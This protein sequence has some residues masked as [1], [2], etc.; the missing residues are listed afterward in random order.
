MK[1]QELELI[2]EVMQ[3]TGTNRQE[4]ERSV[5]LVIAEMRAMGAT[6]AI[7]VKYLPSALE[8]TCRSYKAFNDYAALISQLKNEVSR[9]AGKN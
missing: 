2:E 4:A 5:H 8:C 6:P 7:I 9:I 1:K 3:S